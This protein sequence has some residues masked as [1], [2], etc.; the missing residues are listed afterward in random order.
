MAVEGALG[1]SRRAWGVEAM[2]APSVAST[3]SHRAPLESAT[4]KLA[5]KLRTQVAVVAQKPAV[6][7]GARETRRQRPFDI[8]AV[9]PHLPCPSPEGEGRNG[10]IKTEPFRPKA[11]VL[12]FCRGLELARAFVPFICKLAVGH[13]AQDAQLAEFV[14]VVRPREQQGCA[15]QTSIGGAQEELPRNR[16]V[17]SLEFTFATGDQLGEAFPVGR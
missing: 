9:R 13:Y 11:I 14:L 12:P 8:V 16:Y 5:L 10:T 1:A 3:V 4:A 6:L 2:P 15:R 7:E 17:A